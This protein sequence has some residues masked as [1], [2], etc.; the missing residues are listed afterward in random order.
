L[1]EGGNGKAERLKAEIKAVS[2]ALCGGPASMVLIVE[3]REFWERLV[4]ERE[5][6]GRHTK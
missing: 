6:G 2:G 3:G 4:P 1:V 5:P